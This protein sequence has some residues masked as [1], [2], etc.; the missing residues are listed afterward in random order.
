MADTICVW[1]LA[2]IPRER[3]IRRLERD[4]ERS[5][6]VWSCSRKWYLSV[7]SSLSSFCA[8]VRKGERESECVLCVAV[9]NNVEAYIHCEHVTVCVLGFGVQVFRIG[10]EVWCEMSVR[11][12]V[13]FSSSLRSH[14]IHNCDVLPCTHHYRIKLY[15]SHIVRIMYNVSALTCGCC[16]TKNGKQFKDTFM[17]LPVNRYDL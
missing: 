10:Y 5:S 12:A 17:A 1:W 4:R 14:V 11:F 16:Q 3:Q 2:N 15:V 6:V 7:V 13:K 8:C 9:G